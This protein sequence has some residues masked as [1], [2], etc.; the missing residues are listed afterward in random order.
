MSFLVFVFASMASGADGLR[1][2]E[3]SRSSVGMI[4][5]S[6]PSSE[7]FDSLTWA[8]AKEWDRT[9]KAERAAQERRRAKE[10]AAEEEDED[11]A[12]LDLYEDSSRALSL[13]SNHTE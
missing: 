6:T 10:S 1:I 8:Q 13:S 11:L 9:V 2:K 4:P 12:D 7:F 3:R 5:K